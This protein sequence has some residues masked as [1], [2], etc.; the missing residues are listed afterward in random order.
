MSV[1]DTRYTQEVL[2]YLDRGQRERIGVAEW[3]RIHPSPEA[4]SALL[5]VVRSERDDR[6][7]AA[8]LTTLETLG[9]DLEEFLSPEALRLDAAATMSKKTSRSKAIDW[10]DTAGLP[11]LRWMNGD[12]VDGTIVD[13]FLH[14]AAKNK[15]AVPSPIVRRHFSRMTSDSA[16]DFGLSLLE[17]WMERDLMRVSSADALKEATMLAQSQHRMAQQYPA[18]RYTGLTIEQI[19]GMLLPECEAKFAGSA[20]TSQGILALVAASASPTAV[21]LAL[22]YIRKHRSKRASQSKALIEMLAWMDEPRAVQTVMSMANRFNPKALQQEAARQIKLL[23]DHRGW[24][25]D[26]LADR[27]VPDGGFDQRGRRTFEFG[28]RTFTAQLSGN[29]GISLI[30]DSSG[31]TIRSLPR[32]RA[33]EDPEQVKGQ[34]SALKEA[35]ADVAAAQDFQ[36]QRLRR[37][38]ATERTWSSDEFNRYILGHPPMVRLATRLLWSTTVAGVEVLY[39]PL[40]DGSLLT[41]DDE[42]LVL[43]DQ[44]VRIAHG[45]RLD[46]VA[47]EAAATHLSDY[48]VVP[49]FSQLDRRPIEVARG[50][51]T[52]DVVAGCQLSANLLASRARSLGW[53]VADTGGAGFSVGVTTQFADLG[54]EAVLSV[55]RGL[56]LG[57]YDHVDYDC[58]P[59]SLYVIEGGSNRPDEH[60]AL[61]LGQLS[62]VLIAE[63]VDDA[64]II[65]GHPGA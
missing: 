20:R 25:V 32:G 1:I 57:G 7:K 63:I 26:D 54:L 61:E 24:S 21:D 62:P 43:D 11:P 15:S 35:T 28:A 41:M 33:D 47:I 37:A 29:P 4:T 14:S 19:K 44:P 22:S 8:V 2:A 40:V 39:R 36:P 48:E 42:E 9:I 59:S 55:E 17:A 51:R 3:I 45:L 10:L 13:W 23:A 50:Q 65:A 12:L 6:V 30:D 16:T 58:T 27:S 56:F 34:K 52:L 38:M 60:A 31:K 18:H 64:L 46:R 53:Q 5:S 49:L